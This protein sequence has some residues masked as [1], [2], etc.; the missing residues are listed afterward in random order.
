MMRTLGLLGVASLVAACSST[1]TPSSTA[2]SDAGDTGVDA[3]SI[4][5]ELGCTQLAAAYCAKLASCAPFFVNLDYGT[6]DNCRSRFHDQCVANGTAPNG[7]DI[8]ENF[9]TC[10]LAAPGIT[11]NNLYADTLPQACL[12]VPG[13]GANGAA[14]TDSSQCQS[15]FCALGDNSACGVCLDPPAA[16][17]PCAAGATCPH[18]L[19]CASGNC[20]AKGLA[21]AKCSDA[22]PCIAN[23]ECFNGTCTALGAAGEACDIQGKTAVSCDITNSLFCNPTTSKCAPIVP[24]G[25][26]GAVC[27]FSATTGKLTTCGATSYC[28]ANAG[29][30]TV[31]VCVLRSPD[32]GACTSDA[33]LGVG[34]CTPPARCVS[35]TCVQPVPSACSGS[36]SDAGPTDAA[37][38]DAA[39]TDGGVGAE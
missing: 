23:L 20:V 37:P 36:T 28:K 15:T 18:G 4:T 19:T 35:G 32:N 21:G 38:T 17:S 5:I 1:N 2:G 13:K 22:A 25:A 11:C 3:A 7:G 39:P 10:A 30:T 26:L 12:P 33:I 27:G 6:D 16:G 8:G 31:G 14:C 9:Q 24:D 34:P 29:S